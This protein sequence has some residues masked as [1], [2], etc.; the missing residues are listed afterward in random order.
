MEPVDPHTLSARLKDRARSIGFEVAGVACPDASEHGGFYRAW[1]AE[2]RHGAMGYLADD[3]AVSRRED[4][5][6]TLESVRS[7]LVV[8]HEYHQVDPEGVPEDPSLG[9]VARYARGRD[10][11]RVVKRKLRQLHRWLEEETGRSV[12]ARA[13]VD[14]GPILERELAARAGIGWFGKNTM[15]IHPRR[16]SYFF[17]AVLLLDLPLTPDAPFEEDRCGTCRRCLDACPTGALLGRDEDGAPVMEARRCIS[18]LT[19]ENRGPIPRE[20]RPLMGNRVYGCDICQ[21][22]CPFNVRFAEEAAE[23]GY[24]ARGPGERPVGV[25]AAGPAGAGGRGPEESGSEA[26][27]PAGPGS[28]SVGTGGA[29][30]KGGASAETSR[31]NERVR[32]GGRMSDGRRDPHPGTDGP[33]LVELLRMALSEAGWEAFSRG[34]AIRRAGRAGFARNV[35]VAM[36]NWLAGEPEPPAEPV[37][38]LVEALSDP[39]PLVRGHAAWA[40]GRAATD[41][42]RFQ[43]SAFASTE[44]HAW[45]RKELVLAA[46]E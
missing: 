36:G 32:E 44:E 4:L 10:Y 23:P 12:D 11:H 3:S 8:G 1:L 34:S 28:E 25:E 15:L 46:G 43:L 16:G 20:L 21:E 17:L 14:T 2:G 33:S 38:V 7:V 27:G 6:L 35:C 45:V 19:I 18:Y 29:L 40:L 26:S 9:V 31:H 30:A 41:E 24:A 39:E 13:Y 5:S 42:A 22:V 37:E